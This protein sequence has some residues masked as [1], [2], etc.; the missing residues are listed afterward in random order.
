MSRHDRQLGA[1]IKVYKK[2]FISGAG[3]AFVVVGL[4]FLYAMQDGGLWGKAFF[5]LLTF[6]GVTLCLDAIFFRAK[7]YS[8][9]FLV[10]TIFGR[11][12]IPFDVNTGLMTKIVA[13]DFHFYLRNKNKKVHF[14]GISESEDFHRRLQIVE[15]E[16]ILPLLVEANA[17]G[18][19]VDF[20]ACQIH[21]R[22]LKLPNRTVKLSD[23][24]RAEVKYYTQF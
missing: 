20:G 1:L 6:W 11:K 23:L 7:Y 16:K 12:R 13:G 22:V 9:G 24:N 10:S 19:L 17:S 14:H 18:K 4:A 3:L 2:P 5:S 15:N 21:G 8:K